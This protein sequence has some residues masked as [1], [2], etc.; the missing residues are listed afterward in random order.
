MEV[1]VVAGQAFAGG[2]VELPAV[3]GAGEDAVLDL[4]E[5][6]QVGLQVRAAALDAVAAALPGLL[7]RLLLE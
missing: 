3:E 2:D 1:F 7:L 6:G 5:A 4:A